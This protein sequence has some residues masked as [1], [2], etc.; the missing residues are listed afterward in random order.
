MNSQ[1]DRA[2]L[3]IRVLAVLFGT[4]GLAGCHCSGEPGGTGSA[5]VLA[6]CVGDCG[7]VAR[8]TLRVSRGDGLDFQE[9]VTDLPASGSQWSGRVNGIPVGQGRLFEAVA[10]DAQ[11]H[12]TASG[13]TKHDIEKNA[14]APVDI[15][16]RPPSGPNSPP[17]IDGISASANPVPPG[18]QSTV[19]VA[20][21]D[22]DPGDV[23]GYQWS[24]SCG[25]LANPFSAM[26]R[27][28]APDAE[29]LCSLSVTVS[30]GRG[31]AVVGALTLI[32][33]ST[34]SA[35]VTVGTNDSPVVRGLRA[36]I[37]IG[38]TMT[39][40]L[41]VDALDPDGDPLTFAWSS[42][43][44]GLTFDTAAPRG[45]T[46]P[47]FSLPGPSESCPVTVVVTDPPERGGRTEA[48]LFLP[49]NQPFG[50]CAGVVC[51]TSD[52]CHLDPCNPMSGT[53][54][55][56]VPK[57]CPAGQTCD[58]ADGQCK[59][60]LCTGVVC[61]PA[62]DLCHVAGSCNANTGQCSAQTPVVC[63]GGQTC[64]PTDGQCKGGLCT[65]VVCPPATDLCH[66][67][68]SCNANTGQCSAQTPVVCPG[69]QTCDLADGQCKGGSGGGV[70]AV[71]PQVAKRLDLANSVGVGL[72]TAGNSYVTG[73]L[74]P[75]TKSF[76]GTN[77]TSAG[78]GDVFLGSY[79][80]SGSKRWVV[81]FGDS[82]DQQAQSL[83]VSSAGVLA[84]GRF[85]GL[86]AS[87]PVSI[88]AGASLWDYVLV[89]NPGTGALTA[90]QAI[91]T[92][93]TGILLGSGANPT[94]GHYAV[95]GK[96]GQ[97]AVIGG[98][99]TPW[100]TV[101]GAN[102]YGGSNDIVI[103]V[104]NANGTLRWA[105]QIGT[106]SDE[107]CDA[108]T[109]DDGGNV[110]AAGIYSGT[111]PNLLLAGSTPL[112]NPGSSF[113]RWLWVARFD[114]NTGAGLA[115]AAFGGGAGQHRANALALDSGGNV[116]LAANFTNTIPFDGSHT[117]CTAGGVGCLVS[118]GGLDGLVAKL[119]A[120]FVPRWVTRLGVSTGD[121]S[122][123]GVA[124]DSADDVAVVGALNGSATT[125]TVTPSTIATAPVSSPSISAP[126]GSTSSYLMKVPGATGLF[127]ARTAATTGNANVTNSNKVAINT[128]GTGAVKDAVTFNGELVNGTL[129]FG[130]SST[131]IT[132]TEASSFLVFSKLVSVP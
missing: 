23:L 89:A 19:S 121:D 111:A 35:T 110:V 73:T 122:T 42:T 125:S 86:I 11:G 31:G 112:P 16:L 60:G 130:G 82:A 28:T 105:K 79:D 39:G 43:C 108:V 4:W 123:R 113:R 132:A 55:P 25:H 2:G 13:S 74:V 91:D 80:A 62:T 15:S 93:L 94:L 95:C 51:P 20:A 100:A 63:P 99:S 40:E 90:G 118:D 44:L 101:P 48:T 45:P 77:L 3:S 120:S 104:Y 126:S 114:G 58:P 98:T 24:A 50:S 72:D 14:V 69:G 68:G 115:Q 32:V 127:D 22:P 18:G 26:T 96:A 49:P 97:L 21:H 131:P 8:V 119:D 109:I 129:N 83:A 70:R 17:V 12:Q 78:A 46:H 9:I 56:E 59:G 103:G 41:T 54:G 76:D 30:D 52:K 116:L 65:G 27:W 81:S 128:R 92:G 6:T 102:T 38:P 34:G 64:D 29:G 37:A 124:V 106:A 88:N 66:V 67:A 87:G 84:T 47:G 36:S 85:T 7:A 75:P 107:E 5:Q 71:T 57:D 117:A 53:C 1:S 10:L 33:S 61:P